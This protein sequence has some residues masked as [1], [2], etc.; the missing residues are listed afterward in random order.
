MSNQIQDLT[1]IIVLYQEK[2]ELIKKCLN[3]IKNFKIIIIDNNNDK[4]LRNK[5]NSEFKIYKYILNEKNIGFTK[6]ANMAINLCDTKYILN[7]NADCLIEENAILELL[8]ANQR[9]KNCFITAPIFYNYKNEIIQNSTTFSDKQIYPKWIKEKFDGDTCV[10]WV[11][12]S[13]I[14]F[15]RKMMIE[16]GMFDENLFLFFPD[17][18]ICKR[19][20]NKKKSTIQ[21]T[22]VKATHVHGISKVNNHLK[23]I[24]LRNFHF[25]FDELYYFYK[26]DKHKE[27]FFQLK[28]KIPKYIFKT[29]TNT[30]LLRID[31]A[32][33][34]VSKILAYNK[35][36]KFL[37]KS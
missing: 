37:K 34:Y 32:T 21:L 33:M 14:L 12:G 9:Y 26:I 35:F 23:G 17:E 5:I 2:I 1:I 28:K 19:A 22:N 30:F 24:F 36:K 20:L 16:L 10:D 6:A 29:F 13:A 27:I 3:K 8:S 11:L 31:K 4:I 18:D 7:I 25:T 15:E